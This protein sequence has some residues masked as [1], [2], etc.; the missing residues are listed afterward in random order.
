M[1]LSARFSDALAALPTVVRERLDAGADVDW[2]LL[3]DRAVGTG[4]EK[5]ANGS[6][7]LPRPVETLVQQLIGEVGIAPADVLNDVEGSGVAS[8]WVQNVGTEPDGERYRLRNKRSG[9]LLTDVRPA[10]LAGYAVLGMELADVIHRACDTW[11]QAA[12]QAQATPEGGR[13][14]LAGCAVLVHQRLQVSRDAASRPPATIAL[15]RILEDG[16]NAQAFEVREALA[17][18]TFATPGDARAPRAHYYAAETGYRLRAFDIGEARWLLALAEH[19][20][21]DGRAAVVETEAEAADAPVSPGPGDDLGT[22]SDAGTARASEDSP[23]GESTEVP[24]FAGSDTGLPMDDPSLVGVLKSEL[25]TDPPS[26]VAADRDRPPSKARPAPAGDI[27]A[28]SAS[29]ARPERP[30][31]ASVRG[32]AGGNSATLLFGTALEVRSPQAEM[33]LLIQA[34]QRVPT[35]VARRLAE[36]CGI[37]TIELLDRLQDS[38]SIRDLRDSLATEVPGRPAPDWVEE[39]AAKLLL[40]T[41]V[42]TRGGQRTGPAR[43]EPKRLPDG[44]K[45]IDVTSSEWGVLRTI[46]IVEQLHLSLSFASDT[47]TALTLLGD[48]GKEAEWT[49][50]DAAVKQARLTGAERTRLAAAQRIE[51]ELQRVRQ[52]RAAESSTVSSALEEA[53]LTANALKGLQPSERADAGWPADAGLPNPRHPGDIARV[54]AAAENLHR[55]VRAIANRLIVAWVAGGQTDR[56]LRAG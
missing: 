49:L 22:G 47:W 11:T 20:L 31:A 21:S 16:W 15:A 34:A 29:A 24:V 18:R 25:M 51:H 42:Q 9:E 19:A 36:S 7:R 41:G 12:E 17:S 45:V 40:D 27:V 35:A 38:D 56:E 55:D 23:F 53:A 43:L 54:T 2:D 37:G 26:P 8:V 44:L 1:N 5:A 39:L 52:A 30:S 14:D 32:V 4:I 10:A 48:A 3:A 6:A 28:S 46:D 13:D 50:R 33:D